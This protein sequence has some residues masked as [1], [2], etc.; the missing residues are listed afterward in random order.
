L[1]E[2]T[3]DRFV[4]RHGDPA[5]RRA[6]L[7]A[8]AATDRPARLERIAQL[9]K[10]RAEAFLDFGERNRIGPIAAK[11]LLDAFPGGFSGENRARR[12]YDESGRRMRVMMDELDAVAARLDADGLKMVALK[13]AGIARGIFDDPALCPMGD[14]DVLVSRHRFRD[15][16]ALI[17]DSGFTLKSR[18]A[19]EAADVEAGLES[20]GTEY[21]KQTGGE[22][23]WF[24]LQW[25]PVAG[26]WIRKDQEPDPDALLARSVP[27]EGSA[28]RLLNP[29]DNMIQV[30]L[31]TAKHTYV[32]APGLRLHTDV[33]RLAVFTPPD[34]QAV[35][36]MA[37]ALSVKTAVYFSLAMAKALLDTPI[38]QSVLDDLRP[39]AWKIEAVTRWLARVDVFEPDQHKFRRPDM[40]AFTALLY[41]DAPGLAA[42]VFDTDTSRLGLRHLPANLSRGAKRMFDVVTRF[43]R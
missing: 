25:R 3:Q 14:L 15:A 33:D 18:A 37:K 10:S 26:R 4:Q 13:N 35:G 22:E 36:A 2:P 39:P 23:V 17:L 11:A 16:H 42:S 7:D 43:Q 19:I 9:G 1:P 5:L 40:M 31:H 24:E 12:I 8:M 38:P 32:R 6:A 20:G 34:W 30:G 41:D 27:I 28:V 29:V 21:I